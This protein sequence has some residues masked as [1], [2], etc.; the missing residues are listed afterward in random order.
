MSEIFQIP[1]AVHS[2]RIYPVRDEKN[3]YFDDLRTK[4]EIQNS[5]ASTVLSDNT[6]YFNQE[7]YFGRNT[8]EKADLSVK[9]ARKN[10]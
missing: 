7:K 9:G 3:Q 8:Q 1:I 10:V 5:S 4:T 6:A 2:N